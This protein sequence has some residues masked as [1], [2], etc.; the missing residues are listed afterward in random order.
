MS[1]GTCRLLV[2]AARRLS[3]PYLSRKH[4]SI[5]RLLDRPRRTAG[6]VGI[7]DRDVH[8]IDGISTFYQWVDIFREGALGFRSSSPSP[9]IVDAGANVGMAALF[10]Q[11][12]FPQPEIIAVEPCSLAYACLD[13]NV[14]G[15]PG[16]TLLHKALWSVAGPV[17][18]REHADDTSHIVP[19]AGPMD[20]GT[21]DAITLGSILSGCDREVDFLK[22]DIEGAEVDVLQEA[23]SHLPRVRRMFVEYHQFAGRRQQLSELLAMIADA[24]FV[25]VVDASRRVPQ[26][27][28]RNTAPESL[29][30]TANIYADRVTDP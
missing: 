11:A 15:R 13:R 3:I 30:F 1:R 7:G 5:Y 10:W 28:D 17:P 2:D 29:V 9:L 27:F 4:W 12:S 19:T 18:F 24:G 26:T 16:T 14:G 23:C 8:Y 21:V 25:Y 6:I 22:V 20:Q